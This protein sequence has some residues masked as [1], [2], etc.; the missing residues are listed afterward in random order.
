MA[1]DS[2]NTRAP[3]E[4][5][6]RL[7]GLLMALVAGEDLRVRHAIARTVIKAR[8]S[9]DLKFKTRWPARHDLAANPPVE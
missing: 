7:G 4:F 6:A 2:S 9:D 1:N 8:S 3:S 5:V